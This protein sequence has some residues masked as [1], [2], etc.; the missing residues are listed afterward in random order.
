MSHDVLELTPDGSH[1]LAARQLGLSLPQR[2]LLVRVNGKESLADLARASIHADAVR[3]L[4]LDAERLVHKGLVRWVAS[5]PA[6]AG[7]S[8]VDTPDTGPGLDSAAG[9]ASSPVVAPA[10]P[11]RPPSAAEPARPAPGKR[12]WLLLLA[13]CAAGVIAVAMGLGLRAGPDAPLAPPAPLAM[14]PSPPTPA[15]PAT[16]I[17]A[18]PVALPRGDAAV[19]AASV[20]PPPPAPVLSEPTPTLAPSTPAA[21]VLTPTPS[22]VPAPLPAVAPPGRSAELSPALP[23]PLAVFAPVALAPPAT[24][25][26]PPGTTQQGTN[27]AAMQPVFRPQPRLPREWQDDARTVVRFNATLAVEANG[28]VSQVTFSGVTPADAALVRA[29]R[30][31]LLLWRF[32]EG[33]AGRSH[34]LELVFRAE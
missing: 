23:P 26:T 33:A 31:T 1:E 27:P 14:A 5:L 17:S 25:V 16:P 18:N 20:T 10:A 3:R 12:P 22:A 7:A 29:S 32:P 30:Q 19:P 4:P 15:A 8:A 21:A 28:T 9:A 6:A 11:T 13:G 24:G 2:W 34:A